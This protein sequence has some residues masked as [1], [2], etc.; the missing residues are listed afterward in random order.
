MP[1]IIVGPPLGLAG[2]QRQQRLRAIE[3]LDLTLLIDA[4]HDGAVGRVQIE[5]DDVAHL[6]DKGRVARQLEG[7]AAMRLQTKSAPDPTDGRYRKAAH[8]G[9]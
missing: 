4:Q 6:L 2:S 1:L 7:F 9:H 5:T 3:R 8:L